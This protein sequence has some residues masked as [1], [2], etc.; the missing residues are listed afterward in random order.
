MFVRTSLHLLRD[1]PLG[2]FHASGVDGGLGEVAFGVRIQRLKTDL[3]ARLLESEDP[4]VRELAREQRLLEPTS[5]PFGRKREEW[6]L[7]SGSLNGSVDCRGL[8]EATLSPV[9][10]ASLDR[11]GPNEGW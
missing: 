3:I 11:V 7:W 8:R 1:T 9:S 2:Y 4:A 5:T 10:A 6:G